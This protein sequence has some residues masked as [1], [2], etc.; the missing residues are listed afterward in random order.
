MQ[1]F[2]QQIKL[3]IVCELFS[4]FDRGSC[5]SWKHCCDSVSSTQRYAEVTCSRPGL[6]SYLD[7]SRQLVVYLPKNFYKNIY[8]KN[9]GLYQNLLELLRGASF[10]S[11]AQDFQNHSS[12]TYSGNKLYFNKSMT[13]V[14]FRQ[15]IFIIFNT[16]LMLHKY[17]HVTT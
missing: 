5:V 15:D 14:R 6:H 8:R 9:S 3:T 11:V 4:G 17:T 13:A 10:T 12:L 1:T 2:K 7:I 16:S